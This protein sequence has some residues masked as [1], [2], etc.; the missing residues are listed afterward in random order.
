MNYITYKFYVRV[1]TVNLY[2]SITW[3]NRNSRGRPFYFGLD[4]FWFKKRTVKTKIK[5]PADF[6]RFIKIMPKRG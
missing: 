6:L 2:Y 4:I 3:L 1:L 5:E